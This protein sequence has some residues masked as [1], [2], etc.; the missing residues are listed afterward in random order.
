MKRYYRG[1]VR[2]LLPLF[3][4]TAI[5]I[6][7]CITDIQQGIQACITS[8]PTPTP[9]ATPTPGLPISFVASNSKTQSNGTPL[10]ETAPAG[11]QSGDVEV[12]AIVFD[13]GAGVL[14]PPAGWNLVRNNLAAGGFLSTSVYDHIVTNDVGGTTTY[15][16]G[17]AATGLF[18]TSIISA[19]RNVSTITPVEGAIDATGTTTPPTAP[20]MVTVNANDQLVTV[21]GLGAAGFTSPAD[22]TNRGLLQFVGGTNYGVSLS[23]K[24]LTAAG[25]VPAE[26]GGGAISRWTGISFGL[27]PAA[28]P[29]L[30]NNDEFSGP[31]GG[32]VNVKTS[33]G[34]IGNGVADDTSAIQTCLTNLQSAGGVLFFPAGTYLISSALTYNSGTGMQVIGA[35]PATTIIK[36]NGSAGGT[37]WSQPV[38]LHYCKVARLTF[39]ANHSAATIISQNVPGGSG[40]F[41]LD[42][43]FEN[44]TGIAV[45]VP[46]NGSLDS[47]ETMLRAKFLNNGTGIRINS[48]NAVDWWIW[49]STF[50]NNGTGINTSVGA[51]AV[52]YSNFIGQN[53]VD[54]TQ[55]DTQMS[56]SFGSVS[57]GS[58]QFF[59]NSGGGAGNRNTFQ[60]NRIFNTTQPIAINIGS[61]ESALAIDNQIVT[62]SGTTAI[63]QTNGTAGT[64]ILSV[65][66]KFTVA[67]PAETNSSGTARQIQ[68]NDSQVAANTI[69]TSIPIYATPPNLGRVVTE[70]TAGSSAATINSAINAAIV[71]NRSV[72]H[73]QKGSYSITTPITIPANSDVQIIGD[74]DATS[75][76]CSGSCGSVFLLHS[77][78]KA[79]ISDMDINSG[80]GEGI[81]VHTA[82]VAGSRVQIRQVHSP[83]CTV[84]GN[85]FIANGLTNTAVNIMD[86]AL[87]PG[88]SSSH[89]ISVVGNGSAAA[90]SRVGC[91]GCSTGGSGSTSSSP[92]LVVSNQGHLAIVD[93][94]D[95]ENNTP[96]PLIDLS[97]AAA[98]GQ[99][100]LVDGVKAPG[101]NTNTFE[102]NMN[103]FN[104]TAFFA[105]DTF[106]GDGGD[107]GNITIANPTNTT[108]LFY[109]MRFCMLSSQDYWNVVA[110][111]TVALRDSW[112]QNSASSA[113]T[114]SSSPVVRADTGTALVNPAD[115]VNALAFERTV[116]P[117]QNTTLPAGV[118]DVQL[119]ALRVQGGSNGIDVTTPG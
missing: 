43:V 77:P 118:D 20:A 16:F 61:A 6:P 111:G 15:S 107:L 85:T 2:R 56:D 38:G 32:W 90:L 35:D 86:V 81:T 93:N 114:C 88:G 83:N 89:S 50:Q 71:G 10:I 48:F 55:S 116:K 1:A 76:N 80:S 66:N 92:T 21:F 42:D 63:A 7:F 36:W 28:A 39:D 49:F 51:S 5:A 98:S 70:I 25:S 105:S 64:G 78:S 100:S 31:L 59:S 82:D 75:V 12:V 101:I 106:N 119:E 112:L 74:G 14:T 108:A 8:T 22:E 94:W 18:S 99:F 9:S 26:A 60:D 73:L 97:G 109:N 102:I 65:G 19:Y 54:I 87:C 34:A 52:F 95:E 69:S 4:V 45:D 24:A 110:G 23:D 41:W 104:G 27:V 96:T 62:P 79:R 3:A 30:T 72:I 67:L 117:T 58:N 113:S 33:C 37:M 84:T 91:F 47:E 46:N 11:I 103:G 40:V 44:A 29:I 17:F 57:S 115:Y 53:V 68:V 13:S